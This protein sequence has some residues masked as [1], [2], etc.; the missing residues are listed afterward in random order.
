MECVFCQ[1]FWE[2]KPNTTKKNYRLQSIW[3][4][5]FFFSIK[6]LVC[7]VRSDMLKLTTKFR[8]RQERKASKPIEINVSCKWSNKKKNELITSYHNRL[9]SVY[10]AEDHLSD[11]LTDLQETRI[12]TDSNIVIIKNL[13]ESEKEQDR[14]KQK[15]KTQKQ[16]EQETRNTIIIVQQQLSH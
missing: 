1:H 16:E 9:C 3:N 6:Y 10:S 14:P 5:Y 2:N 7:V 4:W 11:L 12:R 15:I 8:R 13:P